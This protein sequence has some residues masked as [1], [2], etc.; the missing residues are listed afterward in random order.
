MNKIGGKM[1]TDATSHH[2]ALKPNGK[3]DLA[4]FHATFKD[5][6]LKDLFEKAF[7]GKFSGEEF[8]SGIKFYTITISWDKRDLFISFVDGFKEE[9]GAKSIKI[10]RPEHFVCF[11]LSI[12]ST[13]NKSFRTSFDKEFPYDKLSINDV[14]TIAEKRA[15]AFE[16]FLKRFNSART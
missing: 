13:S 7:K 10:K 6:G 4:Y 1:K 3:K 14:A 15:K 2:V 5:V 16:E 11:G 9:H 8:I 12:T